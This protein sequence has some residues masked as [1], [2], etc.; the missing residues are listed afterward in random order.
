MWISFEANENQHLQIPI[1]LGWR[2]VMKGFSIWYSYMKTAF[3]K[4]L[5]AGCFS[6]RFFPAPDPLK[7][8]AMIDSFS[9]EWLNL[10]HVES[11]QQSQ[12]TQRG[13]PAPLYQLYAKAPTPPNYYVNL[14]T[15]TDLNAS[16]YIFT[17]S[18]F[19]TQPL[20][21]PLGWFGFTS[22]NMDCKPPQRGLKVA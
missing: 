11:N 21:N 17:T 4:C 14:T 5:L 10:Y 12:L 13:L 19:A 7:C 16:C 9:E 3:S 8:V 1:W 15:K 6:L 22:L 2:T 20:R 18:F